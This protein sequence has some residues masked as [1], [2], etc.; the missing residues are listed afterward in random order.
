MERKKAAALRRELDGTVSNTLQQAPS[1]TFGN[2]MFAW[3]NAPHTALQWDSDGLYGGFS[4]LPLPSS[5]GPEQDFEMSFEEPTL[6]FQP[7]TVDHPR[8]SLDGSPSQAP[9]TLVTDF[10]PSLESSLLTHDDP[11][12]TDDHNIGECLRNGSE[13]ALSPTSTLPVT[14]RNNNPPA[15]SRPRTSTPDAGY[16]A[17]PLLVLA[18]A[19]STCLPI[20]IPDARLSHVSEGLCS[21]P[22]QENIMETESAA[23]CSNTS[24]TNCIPL[25]QTGID[26]ASTSSHP[27][28]LR[29]YRHLV[30]KRPSHSF[31]GRNESGALPRLSSK[32]PVTDEC[33]PTSSVHRRDSLMCNG[34]PCSS[35]LCLRSPFLLASRHEH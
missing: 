20:D 18:T 11:E 34:Q 25:P 1:A 4:T 33:G 9:A 13:P 35:T 23:Q 3:P 12:Q 2:D 28:P 29:H 19:S 24:N 27:D 22:P 8:S 16:A 21:S 6:A 32:L 7:P 17:I 10:R 30:K 26:T 15:S 31:S 5:A 14:E